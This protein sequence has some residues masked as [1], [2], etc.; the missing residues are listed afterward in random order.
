[1]PVFDTREERWAEFAVRLK[2]DNS[3]Y[4]AKIYQKN[5]MLQ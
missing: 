5:R 3:M 2:I 4:K 1:M